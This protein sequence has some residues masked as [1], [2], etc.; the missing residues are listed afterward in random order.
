MNK[1]IKAV[2][3]GNLHKSL[4]I[5]P[6]CI[7]GIIKTGFVPRGVKVYRVKQIQGQSK[8]FQL[9]SL[10]ESRSIKHWVIHAYTM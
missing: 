7:V 2:K 8:Q 1:I 5:N 10:E 9:K 6:T 4:L 3:H